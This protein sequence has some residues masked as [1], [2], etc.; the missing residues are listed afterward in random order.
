M[1]PSGRLSWYDFQCRP[2]A[3]N[4]SPIVLPTAG[5]AGTDLTPSRSASATN[6]PAI[7]FQVSTAGVSA[8]LPEPQMGQMLPVSTFT[9]ALPPPSSAL[10]MPLEMLGVQAVLPQSGALSL[11]IAKLDPPT[12][13]R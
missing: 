11:R 7:S 12:I 5:A 6:G 10:T 2:F 8:S 9:G 1:D 3:S 13:S 4:W